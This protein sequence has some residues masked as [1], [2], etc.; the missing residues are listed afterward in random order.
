MTSLFE[1]CSA[2]DIDFDFG[3]DKKL[4]AH[5]AIL[6]HHLPEGFVS[7]E[8]DIVDMK[9]LNCDYE[10]FKKIIEYCYLND[11]SILKYDS[12]RKESLNTLLNTYRYLKEEEKLLEKNHFKELMNELR[13]HIYEDLKHDKEVFTSVVNFSYELDAE[14]L[15]FI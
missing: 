13:K 8:N 14:H 12:K 2:S 3:N 1:Y 7:L 10:T 6:Y 15:F 11:T 5:K 9:S 4:K